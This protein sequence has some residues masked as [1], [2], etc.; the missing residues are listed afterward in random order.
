MH[1]Q[2]SVDYFRP[3]PCVSVMACTRLSQS[4]NAVRKAVTL[5]ASVSPAT[6]ALGA[7][8][9]KSTAAAAV[10]ESLMSKLPA[11]LDVLAHSDLFRSAAV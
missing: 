5:D 6:A 1:V 7:Q 4:P 8:H 10:C 11:A 9:V 2:G 3:N